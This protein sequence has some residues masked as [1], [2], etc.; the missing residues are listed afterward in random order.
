VSSSP[1]KALVFA[2]G[3]GTRMRPITL[4]LPKPLVRI[5]GRTMLDHMLDRLSESGVEEAIVNV[6]WLADQVEAQVATRKA[7][8]IKISDERE[9]LLD[10]GGGIVKVL[11]EFA[12][13][14]FYICNTDALWIDDPRPQIARLAEIWDG[15]KMDALLLLADR[16]SSLGVEG[17][18]DFFRDA[19]GRLTRPAPGAEAPFIYSGV[20][21][22]KSSL[23]A[24]APLAP[25]R[26]APYFFAAAERGRLFGLPLEGRW[27]HVG[28]P[29]V[30]DEAEKVFAATAS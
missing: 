20:G 11:S 24:G 27:L 30:I 8:R 15:E 4:T 10:Q 28:A 6:H 2:A 9:L 13:K 5:G 19:E 25:F 26:L 22:L 12:G 14:P 7:P 1:D 3:L 29:E 17:R 21:I 23:F 18:G 16:Q